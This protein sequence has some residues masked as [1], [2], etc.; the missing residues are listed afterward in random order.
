MKS[1]KVLA[2]LAL[3]VFSTSVSAQQRSTAARTA[4]AK[5]NYVINQAGRLERILLPM[6]SFNIQ[7]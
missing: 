3:L 6:E 2:V 7:V 1:I 5:K 4:A